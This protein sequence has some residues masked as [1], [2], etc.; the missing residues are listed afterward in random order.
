[1]N[2]FE[3]VK[4]LSKQN[5]VVSLPQKQNVFRAFG[6]PGPC[7]VPGISQCELDLG[8]TYLVNCLT[9]KIVPQAY[10]DDS[11][12]YSYT[13][14]FSINSEDWITLADY[15]KYSCYKKQS[16]CFPVQAMR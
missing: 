16:F 10:L 5:M 4:V 2:Y 1:M 3:K 15:S 12:C 9:F 6:A 14:R 8:N 11:M 7:P 13:L